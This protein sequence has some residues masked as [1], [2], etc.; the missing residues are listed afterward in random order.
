MYGAASTVEVVQSKE[1]EKPKTSR[2][3]RWSYDEDDESDDVV[4][5]LGRNCFFQISI[6]AAPKGA[7]LSFSFSFSS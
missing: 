7:F 5:L 4:A 6:Q 1:G 3:T 2:S